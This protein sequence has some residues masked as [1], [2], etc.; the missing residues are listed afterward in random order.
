M[1]SR[2]PGAARRAVEP[3]TEM[4]P[5]AFGTDGVG[6]EAF[7]VV[8][9]PDLDLFV[10]QDVGRFKQVFVDCARAPRSAIPNAWS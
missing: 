10:F 3:L 6:G 2:S 7:A 9:V 5:T 1:I 4:M 8:D